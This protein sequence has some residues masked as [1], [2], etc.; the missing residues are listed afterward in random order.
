[1]HKLRGKEWSYKKPKALLS[2]KKWLEMQ[3][4]NPNDLNADE[5]IEDEFPEDE[6]EQPEEIKFD[7]ESIMQPET[8]MDTGPTAGAGTLIQSN[9]YAKYGQRYQIKFFNDPT[10]LLGASCPMKPDKIDYTRISMFKLG[11]NP[12]YTESV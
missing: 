12:T 10:Y 4:E 8:S 7:E 5:L 3:L 6:G 1:M 2:Y 11:Y 9:P